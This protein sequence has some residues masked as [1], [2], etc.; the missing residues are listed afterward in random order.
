M[1]SRRLS[2][3]TDEV[4]E[5]PR[6]APGAGRR[7]S[8]VPSGIPSSAIRLAAALESDNIEPPSSPL[9]SKAR[10]SSVAPSIRSVR[11]LRP[12]P[13][14]SE[15][16]ADDVDELSPVQPRD[17]SA[18]DED[19]SELQPI[20]E[21]EEDVP[22]E[23]PADVTEEPMADDEA[24]EIN[25]LEAA[26]TIGRKRPR[27]S[28]R[29]H[30][31]E[32]GS[33]HRDEAEEEAEEADGEPAPKRRRGRQAIKSP[34]KQKQPATK[35]KAKPTSRTKSPKAIAKRAPKAKTAPKARH[36]SNRRQSADDNTASI[37]VTVQ[38]F[39]NVKRRSK[40]DDEDDP[41]HSEVPFS[42]R[43]ETVVD[44]FAQ[45]CKEVIDST[46]NQ[47]HE[48]GGA[49]EDRN[50]KKE[51]RIKMRAIEAYREELNSRLLQHV[52]RPTLFKDTGLMQAGNPSQRLAVFEETSPAG[53][54]RKDWSPRGNHATQGR[55]RA[56]C[57]S[58]GCGANQARR[59][60]QRVQGKPNQYSCGLK[61]SS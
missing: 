10:R 2:R 31:P 13:R 30:S 29:R 25:E 23:P 50:K 4:E 37:E 9:V 7:R 8:M 53:A 55:T 22:D 15:A 39:V 48:V 6:D 26:K 18:A 36:E 49:T 45:V 60:H 32:L 46:I 1:S 20:E 41:L 17:E 28:P 35:P 14:R 27:R 51:F 12:S 21:G 5:S 3:L 57:P 47:L 33:R 58:D 11:S 34:A 42:T 52:S 43:G 16:E 24:E 54:A 61:Q 44:V 59:G 40:S 38:R 56:G 19:V